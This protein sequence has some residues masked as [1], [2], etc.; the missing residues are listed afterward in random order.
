MYEY[1]DEPLASASAPGP[2]AAAG[3]AAAPAG[4]E[5]PATAVVATAAG[6]AAAAEGGAATSAVVFAAAVASR[7]IQ[8]G[9][10][11]AAVGAEPGPAAAAGAV[12]A[13]AGVEDPATAVVAAAPA[14]V[15]GPETAVVALVI[16]FAARALSEGVSAAAATILARD[17]FFA[18]ATAV[19]AAA[20]PATAVEPLQSEIESSSDSPSVTRSTTKHP[21]ARG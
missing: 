10:G 2:A 18:P 16:I 8:I 20:T 13:P 14:G 21:G 3:A 17:I 12:A 1:S 11:A 7:C 5:D 6:V 4:V 9:C 19:R 15:E